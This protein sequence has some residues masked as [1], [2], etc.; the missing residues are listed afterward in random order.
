[1]N[2]KNSLQQMIEEEEGIFRKVRNHI[3]DNYSR[4]LSLEEVSRETNVDIKIISKW[5]NEGKLKIGKPNHQSKDDLMTEI[6]KSR[7][8]MIKE[9]EKKK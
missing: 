3:R 9:L 2:K 8:E 6:I 5:V 4:R 7:D 1:M